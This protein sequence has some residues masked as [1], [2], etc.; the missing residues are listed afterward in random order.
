MLMPLLAMASLILASSPGL[1]G[2]EMM[3]AFGLPSCSLRH[4][5]LR[6]DAR[7]SRPAMH[8]ILG[9][10]SLTALVTIQ[11]DHVADS[12]RPDRKGRWRATVR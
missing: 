3:K 10:L 2:A 8:R 7:Q 5:R 9:A 1:F 11:S 6:W 4:G 12:S